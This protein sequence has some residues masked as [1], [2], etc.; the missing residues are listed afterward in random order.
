[1]NKM[2]MTVAELSMA[3]ERE[4]GPDSTALPRENIIKARTSPPTRPK[5]PMLRLQE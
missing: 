4:E 2:G 1:M 5:I 3:K